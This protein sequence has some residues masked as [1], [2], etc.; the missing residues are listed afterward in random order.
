[1][2]TKIR[3]QYT[4]TEKVAL[5]HMPGL[6]MQCIAGVLMGREL[7]FK[8]IDKNAYCISLVGI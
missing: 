6:D 2:L 7:E 3:M 4:D 5:L 8:S 1:M